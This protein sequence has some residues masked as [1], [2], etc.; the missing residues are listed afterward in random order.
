[1]K[2]AVKKQEGVRMEKKSDE[3]TI[4]DAFVNVAPYFNRLLNDDVTIS[5]Y[6]TKK[7]VCNVPGETFSLNTR[8]GDPLSDDDQDIMTVTIRENK[9]C[10]AILPADVLGVPIVS[11]TIPLHDD[12]GNVIGAVGTGMSTEQYHHL[13]DI[14]TSLSQEINQAS[15]TVDTMTNSILDLADNI[16]R[17]SEQASRASGS[18]TDIDSIASTVGKIADQSNLLGLNASIEAARA[19]SEGRGFA[20][21]ADEVRKLAITSKDH[22]SDINQT[23]AEV[24]DLIEQLD[25]AIVHINEQSEEQSSAIHGIAQAM[26]KIN[27]DVQRLAKLAEKTIQME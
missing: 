27:E 17:V 19:G 24:R 23:T 3:M 6:D 22:A 11:K 2:N 26:Q 15:N 1:M 4:L 18:L 8:I 9:E 10:A 5:I 14:A 16:N 25:K 7:L 21:V 13:F 12:N 20:V